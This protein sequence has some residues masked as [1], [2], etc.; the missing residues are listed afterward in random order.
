MYREKKLSDIL[1]FRLNYKNSS[2]PVSRTIASNTFH[3]LGFLFPWVGEQTLN[4]LPL[5]DS[6]SHVSGAE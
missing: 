5:T 6:C 1:L 2:A 4:L 3:D